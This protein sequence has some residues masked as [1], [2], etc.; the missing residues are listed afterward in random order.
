MEEVAKERGRGRE[1]RGGEEEN[2][3]SISK[4]CLSLEG[5][6]IIYGTKKEKREDGKEI[7]NWRGEREKIT[8]KRLKSREGGDGKG[9]EGR[10][11]GEQIEI[12]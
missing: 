4:V 8:R 2:E 11:G 7:S 9:E 6:I 5:A 3:K 1:R 12:N 10:R